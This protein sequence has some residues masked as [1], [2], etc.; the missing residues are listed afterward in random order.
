[1]TDLAGLHGLLTASQ[2]HY[3]RQRQALA[4]LLAEET[5][6]RRELARL[7]AM[8]RAQAGGPV[9]EMQLLGADVLWQAWVGRTKTRLNLRLS[10]VLARKGTEQAKVRKAFGKVTALSEL[11]EAEK[12]R[13]RSKS[14]K[15]TLDRAIRHGPQTGLD[16]RPEHWS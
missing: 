7:D 5:T 16:G 3:E 14:A 15:A 6:L 11:I 10:R 4:G 12:T 9:S 13:I 8:N 1:M 2:L